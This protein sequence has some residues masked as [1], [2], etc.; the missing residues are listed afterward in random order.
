MRPTRRS[1]AADDAVGG[2]I[3]AAGGPEEFLERYAVDALRR[4]RPDDRERGDA[5]AGHLS[6]RARRPPRTGPAMVYSAP[7]RRALAAS[8]G[9]APGGRCRPL[10][11]GRRSGRAPRRGG[12][13]LLDARARAGDAAILDH[14]DGFERP[15]PRCANPNAGELLVSAAPGWEFA[16][17]AGRHHAGGGSHGSLD[18]G[19]SEV[20]M[21]TVGLDALPGSITE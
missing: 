8:S 14:P 7:T 19:D 5:A 11:R 3:E 13:P 18:A 6:G 20:P 16:D 4:P 1:R 17:L 12:A 2:L 21:L 10:P 15:G 9:R